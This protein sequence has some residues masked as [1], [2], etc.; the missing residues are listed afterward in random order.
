M[1]RKD[2]TLTVLFRPMHVKNQEWKIMHLQLQLQQIT[3]QKQPGRSYKLHTETI[4]RTDLSQDGS[5]SQYTDY[6]VRKLIQTKT[7]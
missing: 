6:Q 5:I 3:R 4:K 2:F 1:I 7:H